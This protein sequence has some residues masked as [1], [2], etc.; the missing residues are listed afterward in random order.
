L[1]Q[2]SENEIR[3]LVDF[4]GLEMEP[5]CLTPHLNSRVVITA[6]QAQVR[7]PIHTRSI[8]SAMRYRFH[9]GPL[10][11]VEKAA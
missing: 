3:R 4:C 9:L 8:G 5:A 11:G 1:V 6:S 7:E 10:L 2:D